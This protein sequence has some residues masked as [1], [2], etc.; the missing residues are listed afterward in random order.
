MTTC[1]QICNTIDDSS[2]EA[3]RSGLARIIVTTIKSFAIVIGI[4]R[5]K[6]SNNMRLLILLMPFEIF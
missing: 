3:N 5:F 1:K 2:S 6:K 4:K